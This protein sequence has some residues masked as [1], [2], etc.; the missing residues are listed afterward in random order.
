MFNEVKI[1]YRLI[2]FNTF[3]YDYNWTAYIIETKDHDVIV[4]QMLLF[5]PPILDKLTSFLLLMPIINQSINQSK[6][7]IIVLHNT[8]YSLSS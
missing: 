2:R 7:K 3:H 8:L 6:V 1:L 5:V 4:F